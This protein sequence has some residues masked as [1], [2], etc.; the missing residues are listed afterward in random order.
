MRLSNGHAALLGLVLAAGMAA[1][2]DD[3]E[4][5][6]P[7]ASGPALSEASLTTLAAEVRWSVRRGCVR[8]WS[9]SAARWRST[10]S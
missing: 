10:R 9:S 2:S 1:C 8:R 6:A 3:Q 7:T 5:V 4:A